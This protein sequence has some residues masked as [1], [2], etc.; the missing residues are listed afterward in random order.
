M[1]TLA[2]LKR[3]LTVGQKVIL[4]ERNKK[5]INQEKEVVKVQSNAWVF[6]TEKVARS[7]LQ[8]PK[9]SLIEFD[10]K[11]IKI[12]ATG[13]RTLTD[14]EA[15]IKSGYEAIRNRKQEEIDMLSDGSTSFYIEKGY[16][17]KHNAEYLIG[18]TTQRGMRYDYN[19]GLVYDE[20]VKGDLI[21]IY[22]II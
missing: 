5:E 14:G 21:L 2:D 9:A 11:T 3:V 19:S 12:Y 8:F 4:K 20:K 15:K 10:G 7:W 6:K 13:K 17:R 1:K 22:E 18:H 16:Y